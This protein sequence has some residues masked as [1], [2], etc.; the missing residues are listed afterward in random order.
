[1]Q[2]PKLN[3]LT[4]DLLIVEALKEAEQ[5]WADGWRSPSRRN[6]EKAMSLSNGRID[7]HPWADICK[8]QFQKIAARQSTE[9]INCA[10]EMVDDFDDGK[11]FANGLGIV[12]LGRRLKISAGIMNGQ[13][14]NNGPLCGAILQAQEILSKARGQTVRGG[15]TRVTCQCCLTPLGPDAVGPYAPECWA[16]L[17]EAQRLDEI[18]TAE[19]RRTAR[20]VAA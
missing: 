19:L 15:L 11:L 20:R 16:E 13:K 7:A 6:I 3:R 9:I 18:Y 5:A 12:E 17:Q 10:Q 2:M 1:M 14:A 4:E 8:I